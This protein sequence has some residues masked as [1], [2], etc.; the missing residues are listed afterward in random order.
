V[1]LG[2]SLHPLP[3]LRLKRFIPL[4]LLGLHKVDR[5]VLVF[6]KNAPNVLYY[7]ALNYNSLSKKIN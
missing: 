2:F 1:I 6:I 3:R 7:I 4:L 5:A